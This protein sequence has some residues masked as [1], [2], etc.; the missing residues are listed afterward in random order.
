[1]SC[2]RQR[3]RTDR[4]PTVDETDLAGTGFP[5]VKERAR[6]TTAP[7]APSNL[8]LRHGQAPGDVGGMFTPPPGSNTRT[9]E[10]EWTLDPINGPSTRIEPF[11]NS[12]G[13]LF[14]GLPR[15]KDVWGRGRARNTIGASAWSDPATIMVT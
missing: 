6:S 10:G 5:L 11:T 15:G 2:P 9:F 14:P 1:M 13:L 3:Q 12:R 7:D 4:E 8:R